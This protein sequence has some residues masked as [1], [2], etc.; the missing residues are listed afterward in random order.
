[1]KNH[2]FV[3]LAFGLFLSSCAINQP[4][5]F[6]DKLTPTTNID[7]FYST[8]DVKKDYKVIGHMNYPNVGQEQ[9]KQVFVGYAKKIGADAIV[10]TG[11]NVDYSG[12]TGSDVVNA[13]VLKYNN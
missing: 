9:V 13:D 8:H 6:G 10:I 2:H 4:S 5:Y 1:M 7:I 3:I 12:K 11:N